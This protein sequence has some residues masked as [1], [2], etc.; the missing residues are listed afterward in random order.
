MTARKRKILIVDDDAG[1]RASLAV[2]LQKWGFEPLQASDAA[3]ATQLVERHDPDLVITDVV[4]PEVSGLD[5]LRELKAGDPHRPVLL[6]TAQG[7]IDMA[8]E[9]MKH[10]ARD[11]LTKPL[12][13]HP[14][15][16]SLLDDAERELELRRKAKRLTARMENEGGPGEFI[17]TSKVM[18]EVFAFVESVAQRDVPVMITGERGTGK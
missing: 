13:D 6:L 3:E 2:L 14:K 12:T 18:R 15:L 11:F 8:V 9:A 17:G 16:K 10:G 1:M 5:L 4:M 7:S